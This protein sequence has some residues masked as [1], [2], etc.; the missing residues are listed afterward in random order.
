MLHVILHLDVYLNQGIALMG[1]WIYVLLFLILFCETGLVVTPFLPGD[2]LLFA[3]GALTATESA[4]LSLS[5]LISLLSVA[6]IAGDAVNYF[7][8]KRLGLRVFRKENKRWFN[9]TQ[10][11]KTEAF[12]ERYGGKTIILARF[13]PIIR[14]FAPFVAGIGSMSYGRFALFN[15]VGGFGWIVSF[16]LAGHY[17]GHLPVIKNNFSLVIL[18]IIFLSLLPAFWEWLRPVRK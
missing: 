2:S 7:L 12:Y 4:V 6:A 11:L 15:I 1:P 17:F 5:V 13:I 14:T 18:A 16:L 10:L 9:R 8:G 3:L